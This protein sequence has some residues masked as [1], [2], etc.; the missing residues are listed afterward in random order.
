MSM[1]HSMTPAAQMSTLVPSYSA[2]V[3]SGGRLVG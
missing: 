1:T 3:D 2:W